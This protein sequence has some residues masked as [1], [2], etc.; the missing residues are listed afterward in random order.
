MLEAVGDVS[1]VTTIPGKIFKLTLM[2]YVGKSQSLRGR[3][4]SL[5]LG[6]C[7]QRVDLF[8]DRF[9]LKKSAALSCYINVSPLRIVPSLH[10]TPLG[11]AHT[12]T[13]TTRGPIDRP[14]KQTLRTM[15]Q[16]TQGIHIPV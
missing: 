3:R 2:A 12:S 13:S 14:L 6:G 9:H 5:F 7:S 10:P 1:Y 8:G 15:S 11:L 4:N 16:P